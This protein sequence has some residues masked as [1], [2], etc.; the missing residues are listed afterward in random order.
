MNPRLVGMRL[1]TSIYGRA[2]PV[3][4]GAQRLAWFLLWYGNFVAKSAAS[5]QGGKGG[6]G[7]AGKG[8]SYVYYAAIEAGLCAGPSSQLGNVWDSQG[9]LLILTG[10]T[11]VTVP[12]TGPYTV[13]VTPPG[14]GS[15]AADIGAARAD[16]YSVFANDYGSPG[17]T[18]YTGTQQTPML[19]VSGSPG[20]GQYSSVV[21]TGPPNTAT[22]T[23]NAADAGKVVTIAYAWQDPSAITS[24]KTNPSAVLDLT[25]F[26]GNQSESPWGFLVSNFPT[27]ALG[28]TLITKVAS[29]SLYLGSSGE[30]PGFTFEVLSRKIFGGGI[31]DTNPYDSLSDML[32]DPIFG[33][34]WTP[35]DLDL[36]NIGGTWK[37]W[38]DYCVSNGLF[39]S[40]LLSGQESASAI[41]ARISQITNSELVCS[42]NVVKFVTYGDTTTIGNGAVFVPNTSPVVDF[43]D[44]DYLVDGEPGG[45]TSDDPLQAVIPTVLDAY[46][47]V[48]LEYLNRANG[49]NAEILEE[50]DD[51]SISQ[52]GVRT[53]PSISLHDITTQQT[54]SLVASHIL[55]RSVN[56][57]TQYRFKVGMQYRYLEPMDLVTVTDS[58]LGLNL[59]PVRILSIEEDDQWR[60]S[61]TAEEFPWGTATPTLY[62]K[63]N[64][65]GTGPNSAADPGNVNTPIIIEANNRV[66]GQQGYELW[67]ALSGQ[68]L[69][70]WGGCHIWMSV[71]GVNYARISDIN[72]ND[73]VVGAA[74]TGVLNALF[75]TSADPDQYVVASGNIVAAG[76][77]ITINF[78]GAVP[79]VTGDLL[80]FNYSPFFMFRGV[81]CT[82]T[83]TGT[84]TIPYSGSGF[85][86]SA[87]VT[88]Y[89]VLEVDLTESGAQLASGSQADADNDRTLCAIVSGSAV[90][91]VSYETADL[92]TQSLYDLIYVRRGQMTSAEASHA[93][94]DAFVRLDS[95]IFRYQ[96]DPT[97]IGQLL[98]F[99]FTSFNTANQMEQSLSEVN[100]YTITPQG[101]FR[102]V[103]DLSLNTPLGTTGAIPPI[104]SGSLTY[105]ATTTSITWTWTSLTLLRPDGTTTAIPNGS[106][107]ITGLTANTHYVFYPYYDEQLKQLLFVPGFNGVGSSSMGAIAQ[108]SANNGATNVATMSYH[109]PL[110]IGGV[111]AATPASG[112]GGGGG[113]GTGICLRSR[114]NVETRRGIV[115][116]GDVRIGD[117]L[118]CPEGWTRVNHVQHVEH[119][120]FIRVV[121]ESGD[122]V[123]VTPTHPFDILDERG[124]QVDRRAK[125]LRLSDLL[126]TRK[127]ASPV[128]SVSV[129]RGEF[130]TSVQCEPCHTFYAGEREPN[131]LTHNVQPIS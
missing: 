78:G 90:E 23:F 38:S 77:T 127:G 112:T 5:V 56:V 12:A 102:G 121:L 125:N 97:L 76:S 15:F 4:Y 84:Y 59:V 118:K 39:I 91:L 122:V 109:V 16:A 106:V 52:I 80:Y 9:I 7:P 116:M 124:N 3:I 33:L 50:K 129:I 61:I 40:L 70:N 130:K 93:A 1:P 14:A 30:L 73:Q 71:D 69:A 92:I 47:D 21:N 17:P 87:P 26:P 131:I 45:E 57:R 89:H 117:E 107:V 111:P 28:Y 58:T 34:Q 20:P 110:S 18:T 114:M 54:A 94:G 85:T 55:Q 72:G 95:A 83:G 36:G 25:F 35:A 79:L 68:K 13:T 11:V 108:T 44:D 104:L 119:S 75:S 101:T 46:N 113:G 32:I 66:T 6:L 51:A 48:F 96:F 64:N 126:F 128:R 62:P 2:I 81:A 105:T 82:K 100:A 10:K 49:Y 27:Q 43:D 53:M 120:V 63:Q 60:L 19:S 37:N 123:E 42:G 103:V 115:R 24:S 65:G 29:P 86:T 8:Q 74:R 88:V 31:V 22:Y 99:K 41:A 98:Y 67:F